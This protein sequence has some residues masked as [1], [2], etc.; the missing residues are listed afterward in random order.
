MTGPDTTGG[1][2]AG[3]VQW[4]R[5]PAVRLWPQMRTLRRP[6]GGLRHWSREC[7]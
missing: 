3:A 2:A 1:L 5:I 6:G 4:R 7:T